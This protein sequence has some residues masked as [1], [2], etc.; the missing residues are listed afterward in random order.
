MYIV[1][2]REELEES[3]RKR[4]RDQSLSK[5]IQCIQWAL[6]NHICMKSSCRR[7]LLI[8]VTFLKASKAGPDFEITMAV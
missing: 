4:G 2:Q 8:W 6:Q 3:Y 1:S 7:P 5:K